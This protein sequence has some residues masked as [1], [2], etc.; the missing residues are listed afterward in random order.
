[1][2]TIEN[3][4]DIVLEHCFQGR[5]NF[6]RLVDLTLLYLIC[7]ARCKYVVMLVMPIFAATLF[8]IESFKN[9]LPSFACSFKSLQPKL[10]FHCS[11]IAGY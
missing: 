8:L 2:N 5:L 3:S 1:M 7:Y 10:I 6:G 11:L 9:S 4:S